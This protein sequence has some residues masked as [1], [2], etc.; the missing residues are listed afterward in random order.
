MSIN[1]ENN[2]IVAG[3]LPDFI[4]ARMLNEFIYCPRLFY[5]E[6]VQGEFVHNEYTLD[7]TFKHKNVDSEMPR[8]R[9]SKNDHAEEN[10]E[11]YHT[12]S[13]MLS[14]PE[15]GAI[16]KIDFA[17]FTGNTVVPVE[18]K[19]G[20]I[21]EIE[22]GAWLNDQVQ[23]CLQMLILRDNGFICDNG[24][25]YFVDSKRRIEIER[26]AELEHLTVK[27]LE[28]MRSIVVK[29]KI[30]PPLEESGKCQKCSLVSICLPDE[31]NL[32]KYSENL[33]NVDKT[34][35]IRRLYP[36][37]DD[38]I[39]LYIQAQGAFIGKEGDLVTIKSNGQK[40]QDVRIMDISQVNIMGNVQ[41][42]SQLL[43][44]L[45]LENIPVCYFTYGNWFYGIT[46][47]MS[48]KNVELRISQYELARDEFRSWSISR[49]FIE[50]KIRNSRTMLRRNARSIDK[51]ILNRMNV[52]IHDAK[53][54]QSLSSL[55]GIEGNA[56]HLYFSN[57]HKLLSQESNF[58]FTSRNR[59]PPRDPVNAMLS[60]LYA[61]L[62]KDITVILLSVGFDPF[63]GFYH[64]PR[65]GRPA[66]ALDLMEEFRS[67]I[68][69]SVVITVLNTN[70]I[71]RG[72]FVSIADT[73]TM[74]P[75][76]KKKVIEA[77]EKRMN[78]LIKHPIF[79][80]SMSYRR[81]IE[82]QA[83]LLARYAMSEI[84]QYKAFV[85]R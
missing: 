20:K 52:S 83:R 51:D 56:A 53:N 2:K 55:L 71:S 5:M 85:T 4:P 35:E 65:Y 77:Y 80:Y 64:Q 76:A 38:R 28:A 50:G 79:G 40:I 59:R 22:G 12:R 30:P 42:S 8:I 3:E 39:P 41:L 7:G 13:L 84:E 75:E 67:V 44:I 43:K 27:S 81:I 23:L 29:K 45:C 46:T 9:K 34:K 74:K 63:L 68:V 21:P 33:E 24:F 1:T 15:L 72:D 17:E 31:T 73:V 19:R 18:Y 58:D 11:K 6:W 37:R 66:L 32:L 36:A 78:E 16:S 69:D 57:F 54:A 70:Q 26:T 49:C 61:V 47:G 60:F 25:I 48:H 10:E 14:S 82:T 62:V